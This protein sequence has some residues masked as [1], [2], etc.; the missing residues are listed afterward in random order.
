MLPVTLP[1]A[2]SMRSITVVARH[3][4]RA[5]D[6]R[7]SC[8]AAA[9][10]AAR[11]GAACGS[12]P[13]CAEPRQGLRGSAAAR[14][15]AR[16]S[17][18][19]S[20]PISRTPVSASSSAAASAVER[21]EV[22]GQ[23]L[24]DV[25]ADLRNAERVDEPRQRRLACSPGSRATRLPADFAPMRSSSASCSAVSR[26]I[27]AKSRTMPRSTS[28]ATSFS[29][30]PVDVER[31]LGGEVADHLAALGRALHADAAIRRRAL[32]AD[33]LAAADRAASRAS[34][35]CAPRRCA[36]LPAPR[37]RTESRRRRAR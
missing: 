12:T 17:R 29:P 23:Q 9:R 10:R 2:A 13:A 19:V 28:C 22:L 18:A 25:L 11:R 26:K 7:T 36:P 32:L 6:A 27:S 20:G 21:A 33:D 31:V 4:Q 30:K 37:R 5:G 15:N 3:R 24:G 14:K 1:P 8:R 34:R 35:I 16:I